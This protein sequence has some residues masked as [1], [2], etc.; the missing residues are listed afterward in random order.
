VAEALQGAV[1]ALG[2]RERDDVGDL[3]V[4][5]RVL[6]AIGQDRIAVGYVEA[7]VDDQALADLLLGVGDA[8]VGVDREAVQ[9]DLDRG[10]VPVVVRFD[11]VNVIAGRGPYSGARRFRS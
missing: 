2:G 10:L 11:A 6:Q 4:V 5:D 8:V 9:L 1:P 7:D 3:G